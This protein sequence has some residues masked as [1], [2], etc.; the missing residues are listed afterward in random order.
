MQRIEVNGLV[1]EFEDDMALMSLLDENADHV[2][3]GIVTEMDG[4]PVWVFGENDR[5]MERNGY[6]VVD[7]RHYGS[8]K[9]PMIFWF[10]ETEGDTPKSKNYGK[11]W[12]AY[13]RRP[14]WKNGGRI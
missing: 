7:F 8:K 10:G 9:A 14:E 2:Y 3:E 4:E 6:A 13:F 1:Y 12:Y 5:D 11:T